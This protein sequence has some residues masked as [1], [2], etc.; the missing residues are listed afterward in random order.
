M[1]NSKILVI[2]IDS[3]EKKTLKLVFS[4]A[5]L[6]SFRS[7]DV[8]SD[9]CEAKDENLAN[10]CAENLIEF[11]PDKKFKL[12]QVIEI[13]GMPIIEVIATDVKITKE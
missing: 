6:I 9:F 10:L 7:G 8:I 4:N 1:N 3:W 2:Y 13:G 11:M 12:F 5:H